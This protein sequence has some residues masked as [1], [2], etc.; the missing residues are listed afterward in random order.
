MKWVL[1]FF[2]LSGRDRSFLIK[3]YVLLTLVRLGLWLFP[4][5]KL[6]KALVRLGRYRNQNAPLRIGPIVHR[7]IWAVNW[8]SKLTP[9]G[10]KCLARALTVKVLLD[11]NQCPADFKIGVAKN[12]A[13]KF[14]AHAWIEVEG[15]VII[16]QLQNLEQFTPMP[17]LPT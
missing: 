4:F 10:A 15:T 1:K 13:G 2:R 14:E 16:G 6:W 3:T 9:G 7:A 8:S 12:S 5:E 11:R 17:S